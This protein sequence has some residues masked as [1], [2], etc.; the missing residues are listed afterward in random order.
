M[1]EQRWRR[2]RRAILVGLYVLFPLSGI[3]TALA[4]CLP[5]TDLPADF[6]PRVDLLF[7]I[8]MSLGLMWLCT[9]DAKLAGKPLIQLAKVGI[10]LG[11]P[12]G[13][14]I[15][16]LWARGIKG[17]GLLLLHGFLLLLAAICAIV[18]VVYIFH[19]TGLLRV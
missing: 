16:L 8:L 11:W 15:Y 13:V 10:F 19:Y 9:V 1:N 2:Q 17:L 7:A 18:A 14:P 4:I 5:S 6:W 3:A 12:I